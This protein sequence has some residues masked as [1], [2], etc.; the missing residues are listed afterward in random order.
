MIRGVHTMFYTSKPDELRAFIR[1][2]LGFPATD[3]GGG[4][5]IFDLPEADMGCHPTDDPQ[6]SPPSGTPDISFYCDDITKTV[7]ELK[8]KG[9][10]FV[11]EVENH[12]YGLVTHFRMPGDF[13]VQL[14]QPLYTKSPAGRKQG[15]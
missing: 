7:T 1:D 13:Q 8:A 10:E 6:C 15:G 3:V 9:V 12:G 2:K 11:N 4:W 14:Y 5:L